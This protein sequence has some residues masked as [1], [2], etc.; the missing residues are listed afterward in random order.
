MK[1][2]ILIFILSFVTLPVFAQVNFDDYFT[3]GTLRF[4]YIRAGNSASND[5][6]FEQLKKE[7]F[8]SGNPKNL[9][10][11]FDYGHYRYFVY[12]SASN[13]LI[14]SKGYD[15]YFNEW[16]STSEAKVVKRSFYETVIFPFPKKTVKLELQERNKKGVFENKFEIFINPGDK[17]IN[18]DM[19]RKFETNKILNSGD[20][21][22]KVDIVFIPEGYTKEEMEKFRK[23]AERFAGYFIECSPYKENKEKINIWTVE[24]I[25]DESGVDNPGLNSWK[26]TIMNFSFYSQ[27]VERYLMSLD[28]KSIRDLASLVPYDNICIISNSDKYGGGAIYNYYTSFPADDKNGNSPYLIVHEFGHHF[29]CLGDEY[30]TSQVSVEDYYSLTV[31]PYEANLTTL[32]NFDKKW[33]SMIDEGIPIPT[34]ATDEYIG[35]LG[36]FEGG[37]YVAKGVYRPMFDCTMKSRS[38]NNFCPVC[39]KAI[40]EMINYYSEK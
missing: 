11:K 26:N 35:K 27:D 2:I 32:V 19:P 21:L 25:S 3:A 16:Q 23:D 8:W 33:K 28:V 36:V 10:D 14:F 1:K 7:P 4:D 9:L 29:A 5:I 13:K 12:D 31:E 38:Y 34:P 22:Y 37:G 20:P 24:A 18:Q 15:T 6:F 30:Y 40:V 17:F 39:K